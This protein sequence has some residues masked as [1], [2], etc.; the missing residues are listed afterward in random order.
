MSRN[1]YYRGSSYAVYLAREIQA[2]NTTLEYVYM[3]L[4][5]HPA[6]PQIYYALRYLLSERHATN[7]MPKDT[8]GY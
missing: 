5:N 7:S 2:G 4:E 1:K 8:E 6:R 3:D